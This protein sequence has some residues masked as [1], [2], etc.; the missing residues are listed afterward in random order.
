MA[1]IKSTSCKGSK[2]LLLA[3]LA[4]FAMSSIL[5]SQSLIIHEIEL[6]DYAIKNIIQGIKS[7]NEG[8]RKSCIY[9]AGKYKI[10]EASEYLIEELT[11][12]DDGELCSLLV[13]SLYQIGNES[14]IKEL[15]IIVKNHNS[16]ELKAFCSYLDKIKEFEIAITKNDNS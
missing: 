9:I 11:S 15:Q 14:Y 13:W 6:P 8:V 7:E 10:Q 2:V 3:V 4:L 12:L 1:T 16:L 5:N